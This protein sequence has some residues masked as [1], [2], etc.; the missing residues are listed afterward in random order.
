MTP[1]P[2]VFGE[3]ANLARTGPTVV[4][5]RGDSG[6]WAENTL[7]AFRA[8]RRAGVRMQE[9]DVRSSRDGVL[10]CIHDATLD[11]TTD[12]ATK[13][14]PGALVAEQTL[15]AIRDLDAGSWRGERC[16]GARVPTLA[17]VAEALGPTGIAMVEHKAGPA[18][19]YV[20]ELRRLGLAERAILQSFD[21]TFVAAARELA[22]E[23]A[24]ALLG[25]TRACPALDENAVAAAARLGAGMLHW[26]I[27]RIG[28]ETVARCHAAGLLVCSY[29]TDDDVGFCGGAAIGID[30]M[31]T[32]RPERMLELRARVARGQPRTG[33]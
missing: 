16:R 18:T 26:A 32:N 27:D 33:A 2:S 10:V 29:T 31:C 28:P 20:H 19:A 14:G 9:F 21:W 11:R 4:A 5:H 15:A 1:T 25:P 3:L 13:L 12:A 24:V 17:E 8:A 30:A 6:L 22:P 23:L 7:P